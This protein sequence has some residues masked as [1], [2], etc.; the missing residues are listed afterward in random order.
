MRNQVVT[1]FGGTGFIGRQLVQHLAQLG[2]ALRVPTRDPDRAG[3][4]RPMGDVGQIAILPYSA[5][6][7]GVARLVRGAAGVVNLIGILHERRDGDFQRVHRDFAGSV[8]GAAAAAGARRLVHL[9]AIGADPDGAANYARS[10]GEGEAAVRRAFPDATILRPSIV[11]GPGDGF[12]TRFARMSMHSPVL[13]LIEGGRTRFQPV[14]VGDVIQAITTCLADD[15]G[16][17]RTFELGGPRVATFEA[18][19]R[20]LLDTLHR[21]RLLLPVSAGMAALPARLL[22]HLPT[23]PLTRDQIKLLETDNVVGPDALTLADLGIQPTP[24]ETVVPRYLA[25]FRR[26]QPRVRPA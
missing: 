16:R 20:Y 13:P 5:D 18:L 4:L 6:P 3:F 9:S 24:L 25:P 17:G 8:A 14:F 7:E 11:F 10:K 19:L 21:H 26:L 12:F 22:E 23:P 1:V 15:V 2:V